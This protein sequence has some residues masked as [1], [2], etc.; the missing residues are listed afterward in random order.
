MIWVAIGAA[1][2]DKIEAVL[3]R[4]AAN[5][6]HHAAVL[7]RPLGRALASVKPVRDPTW[8]LRFSE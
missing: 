7:R 2:F 3:G 1:V 5:S 8:L 4:V 6:R